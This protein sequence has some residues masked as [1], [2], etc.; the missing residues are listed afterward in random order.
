MILFTFSG[1]LEIRKGLTSDSPLLFEYGHESR[2]LTS[3][4]PQPFQGFTSSEGF[5]IAMHMNL[6][7]QSRF[8]FVYGDFQNSPLIS[9]ADQSKKIF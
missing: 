8:G 3:L 9:R 5:Y 7:S 4:D 2:Y 6:S 1:T